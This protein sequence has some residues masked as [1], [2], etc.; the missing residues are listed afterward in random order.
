MFL[1]FYVMAKIQKKYHIVQTFFS[2]NFKI[3]WM[4][5]VLLG[6]KV[7]P[8]LLACFIRESITELTL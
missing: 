2:S 8:V 4:A 5:T 3:I 7:L 6:A 1:E